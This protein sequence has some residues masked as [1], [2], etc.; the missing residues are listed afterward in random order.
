MLRYNIMKI[1]TAT[2]LFQLRLLFISG[3]VKKYWST[4]FTQAYIKFVGCDLEVF[5]AVATSLLTS[6]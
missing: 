3:F 4:D 2:D 5:R 6:K 1:S